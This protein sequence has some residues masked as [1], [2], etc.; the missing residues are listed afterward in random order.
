MGRRPTAAH[1]PERRRIIA[2]SG[3]HPMT[4]YTPETWGVGIS[5]MADRLGVA[6]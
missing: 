1:T 4:V 5:A 2:A 6:R 3:A